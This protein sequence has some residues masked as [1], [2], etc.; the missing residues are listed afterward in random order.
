MAAGV[1]ILVLGPLE[2]RVDGGSVPISG[3]RARTFLTRLALEPGRV[4]P[5]SRLV[6]AVWDGDEPDGATNAL[7][8]LVARVRRSVPGVVETDGAGYRLSVPP[9]AIDAVRFEQL[10]ARGRRSLADG[11]TTGA[12][13]DLRAALALWRGPAL[14]DAADASFAV[15]AAARLE[16]LRAGAIEDRI[17]ADL[18]GGGDGTLVAELEAL[19]AEHPLRE[20]LN[21]QLVRALAAEGRQAD[22]LAAFQRLRSRLA[23]ELGIDPSEDL[24]AIQLA[25]L[26]GDAARPA[27]PAASQQAPPRGTNLRAQITS[28]VGREADVERIESALDGSRLVTLIGPGGSGKTRLASEVGVRLVDRTP[29]GVWMVELAP[30]GNEGELTQAF[31]SVFGARESGLLPGAAAA[32]SPEERLADAIGERHLLLVVDNCEHLVAAV[33][34]LIDP[35]LARCPSLRVLATSR[36]PLGITGEV[37]LPIDPLPMPDAGAGVA[38]PPSA[39]ESPSVRLFAD[40]AKAV[41]P[42][43]VVDESNVRDVVAICRALDGMPLAIELAAARLRSLTTEQVAARLDDRFRLLGVGGGAALPRHQTLRAVVDWS[44]DLLNEDERVVLRRLAVFP[45]GAVLE[46]A[47]AVCATEEQ[48]ANDVLDVLASLVDKSLVRSASDAA[49]EVRY[50][51]LDTIRAYADERRVDAAEDDAIRRAHAAYLAVVAEE[52]DSHL[53][54]REQLPWLA[55]LGAERDNIHAALRWS[56][57]SGAADLA[58][59]LVVFLGWFWFMRGQ[60]SEA[61]EFSER[62]LV[63]AAE[64]PV[65]LRAGVLVIRATLG[66]T[67]GSTFDEALRRGEE[68]V[69]LIPSIPPERLAKY[70]TL[71]LTEMLVAMFRGDEQRALELAR[72]HFDGPDRWV[73]GVGHLLA[74]Q[75]YSNIGE[76]NDAGLAFDAAVRD[77]RAVGD[78]WGMGNSLF[79]VADLAAMRGE[80]DASTA[81]IE[82]AKEAFRLLDDREDIAQLM[83]RAAME[84]TQ[85]GDVE[86]ATAELDAAQRIAEDLG[87]EEWTLFLDLARADVAR[88]SGRL[89]EARAL[90]DHAIAAFAGYGPALYALFGLLMVGR[91]RVELA[92]GDLEAALGWYLQ[93]VRAGLDGP[94]YPVVARAVEFRADVALSEGNPALAASLL[95]TAEVLRGIPDRADLDVRRVAAAAR[96]AL[97][98][99]AFGAAY[100]RGA[101]RPRAEVVKELDAEAPPS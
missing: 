41:R 68:A 19:V 62:A 18:A 46:A 78:Q 9:E 93:A 42:G 47:G 100:A 76:V 23:D 11:D 28:F 32:L 91:G 43:F 73:S 1:E 13:A 21:G 96:K 10:A 80:R 27:A 50:S 84:R 17:E 33:A 83:I 14:A 26:R 79:A 90:L 49:G 51:M 82:E 54:G 6:D 34:R 65:E 97:G 45:G 57:D 2:V 3:V 44:W 77:F 60:R 67:G 55:R 37:L 98:K 20:R 99:E 22:A 88:V 16:E 85:A 35:L 87:A 63:L 59:R 70:P 29:G 31:L 36:E 52:A 25:V 95:G 92:A 69:A 38:P 71:E 4:V 94:D 56:L 39:V 5:V 12:A 53:R 64:V 81:A 61:L 8:S 89:D 58:T 75:L 30:V 101:G 74:G 7:Q 86:G 72:T 24:Q 15:A 48:D 66:I 40:R